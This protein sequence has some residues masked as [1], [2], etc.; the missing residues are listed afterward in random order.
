MAD[1]DAQL[2]AR[3]AR[4]DSSAL[5][6]LYRRYVQRVWR[7]GWFCTRS[8]DAAEDIVQE[9]FLRVARS[10][11]QFEGRSAFATW[12]FAVTRSV[13][14]EHIRRSRREQALAEVPPVLRLVPPVGAP[15]DEDT[16]GAVRE[17]VAE[18]PAAQRDAIVLCELCGLTIREAAEILA[19]GE[20]RVKVTL[21]RARRRLRDALAPRMNTEESRRSNRV[22]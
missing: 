20:S 4:G 3:Y 10:L 8:R 12:L 6:A 21:F 11:P 5:E 14:V 16:R 9:T 17:A 1:A 13:T 15:I 18:L 19:W 7:Y 2:V 22:R